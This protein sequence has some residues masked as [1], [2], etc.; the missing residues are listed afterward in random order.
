M[1]SRRRLPRRTVRPRR[2]GAHRS[3][4]RKRSGGPGSNL[5]VAHA[6]KTPESPRPA[7]G[8][9]AHPGDRHPRR[10]QH[11]LDGPGL[12]GGRKSDLPGTSG[13]ARGSCGEECGARWL[14]R[15]GGNSRRRGVG[16]VEGAGGRGRCSLRSDL[17]RCGQGEYPRLLRRSH[18]AL[19]EGHPDYRGQR[20]SWRCRPGGGQRGR[21][22]SGSAALQ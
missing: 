1:E 12:A 5:G 13:E 2:P 7:H 10:L 17:H 6:G 3:P 9:T 15:Q 18:E 22:Y 19:P 20:D 8:R 11:D 21:E 4:Y 16:L 14:V